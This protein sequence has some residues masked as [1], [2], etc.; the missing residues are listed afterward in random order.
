MSLTKTEENLV[1]WGGATLILLLIT[2]VSYISHR[3]FEPKKMAKANI[4]IE[5]I[6]SLKRDAT[7][8]KVVSTIMGD[9]QLVGDIKVSPELPGIDSIDEQKED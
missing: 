1:V 3:I 8:I 5:N 4:K 6:L 7:T 9:M 2:L